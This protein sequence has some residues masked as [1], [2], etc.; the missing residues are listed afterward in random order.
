MYNPDL[1]S[2]TWIVSNSPGLQQLINM[3]RQRK[4]LPGAQVCPPSIPN[5]DNLTNKCL[6]C[7][8]GTFWNYDILICMGCAP[9]TTVDFLTRQCAALLV[10]VYQTNLNAS[11]ILYGGI[12][13][14]QIQAQVTKNMARYPGIR[15]CS[16]A[17]PYFNDFGCIAC[18]GLYPLF[19]WTLR[20]CTF[21]PSGSTYHLTS[22]ECLSSSNR[23]INSPPNLGKM[24]SS[25]F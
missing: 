21:C 16:K 13:L 8:P 11:G 15:N 12:S 2:T 24:Y 25:I 19:S 18:P 9:G 6:G 3:T 10:G 17:T 22:K 20:S 1:N 14:A 23:L 4:V 7:P 5:Y